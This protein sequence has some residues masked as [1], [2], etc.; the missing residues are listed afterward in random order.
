MVTPPTKESL[1]SIEAKLVLSFQL[2]PFS[3]YG[4]A[5]LN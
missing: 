3:P 1:Y 5:Y 2:C 4:A